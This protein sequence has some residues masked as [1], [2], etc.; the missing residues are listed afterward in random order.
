M[1][2]V[3]LCAY[4]YVRFDSIFEFGVKYVLTGV[5]CSAV[6]RLNPVGKIFKTIWAFT[7]YLFAPNK[8]S[9]CFPFVECHPHTPNTVVLGLAHQIQPGFGIANFPIVF[10]L[11]YVLKKGLPYPIRRM[12]RF[13]IIVAAVIVIADSF[14]MGVSG[15][16]ILDFAIFMILPSLFCAYSW[17]ASSDGARQNKNRLS[18]VYALLAV[19]IFIG[20]FLFV[21]GTYVDGHGM[22][23]TY[24]PV[25]YRYLEY[26]LGILRNA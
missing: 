15:R 3:P 9:L 14:I 24:D 13:F 11:P 26:S 12:S 23:P 25:L 7:S 4:N 5:D 21:T 17:C 19:S 10:C 22:Q 18:V 20:L 6:S 1:V 16:Y 2:A 8:Y